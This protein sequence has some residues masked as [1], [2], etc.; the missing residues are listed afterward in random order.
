MPTT[1]TAD[2][3]HKFPTEPHSGLVMAHFRFAHNPSSPTFHPATFGS[4][5]DVA[6]LCQI[7]E[8]AMISHIVARIGAKN[9][10]GGELRFIITPACQSSTLTLA[11]L[12]SISISVLSSPLKFEPSAEFVPFRLS[13]SSANSHNM[14]ALK[15]VFQNTTATASY[16]IEG[17]IYYQMNVDRRGGGTQGQP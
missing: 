10:D 3:Y 17:A 6:I 7:P 4:D 2:S 12:G 11:V 13:Y 9:D 16:C 5:S 15:A 1:L 14:C 8:G